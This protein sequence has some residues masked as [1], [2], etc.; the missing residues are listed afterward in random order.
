M[1][2]RIGSSLRKEE[3]MSLKKFYEID[4]TSINNVHLLIIKLVDKTKNCRYVAATL[5]DGEKEKVIN[6]F[7]P[8]RNNTE[9]LTVSK[10]R[11]KGIVEGSI[12]ET[13][14]CKNGDFYNISNWKLNTN[15]E[16]TK[17]DFCHKAP[18]NVDEEYNRIVALIESEI[19]LIAFDKVKTS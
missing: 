13:T 10:L 3:I 5:Y 15:A 4:S 6:M 7:N 16:I 17:L 2:C 19:D 12:L 1:C 18:I 14:I 9:G 8:D 11:E